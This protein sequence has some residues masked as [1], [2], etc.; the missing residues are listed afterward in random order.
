MCGRYTETRRDKALLKSLGVELPAQ[1]MFTPRYNIAPT[2]TAA[3]I[4]EAEDGHRTLRNFKWG[5]IPFW[6]KDEKIGANA[7]NA[8]CETLAEKP[9]FRAS[10]KKKRCLVLADGFFEWQKVGDLKQPIYIRKRGGDP[11]VFGGLWDRWKSP[12]GMEVES[13]SIVTVEPNE[14]A[15]KVHNRMPLMLDVESAIAWLNLKSSPELLGGF[16]GPYPA[17]AMECF[18][19][20]TV[21]NSPKNIGPQCVTPIAPITSVTN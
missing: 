16:L 21:V 8:R 12:T 7:I 1:D 15:A 11:F 6:A 3:V 5:L 18:P 20:S 2:Q 10:F 17:G 9:M 13:F 14:L 4:V 19:V